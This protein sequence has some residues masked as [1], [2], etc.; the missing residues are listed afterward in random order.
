MSLRPVDLT[1]P[2]LTLPFLV[3][4]LPLSASPQCHRVGSPPE[5]PCSTV[6]LVLWV[7]KTAGCHGH[8]LA[9]SLPNPEIPCSSALVA[10]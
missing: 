6:S 8:V 9:P 3:I 10:H 4:D 2:C 7:P 1:C 5:S